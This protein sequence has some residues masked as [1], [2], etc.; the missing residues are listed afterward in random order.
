MG[1]TLRYSSD[2]CFNV[3]SQRLP[4]GFQIQQLD[5][6]EDTLIVVEI[7]RQSKENLTHGL[8]LLVRPRLKTSR[9]V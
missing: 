4:G 6:D 3:L 5:D 7:R 9:L 2:T 1:M 8:K